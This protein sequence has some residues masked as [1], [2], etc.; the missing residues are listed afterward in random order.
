MTP[1]D[2]VVV[3]LETTGLDYKLDRILEIGA[4]RVR[5]GEMIDE[6]QA[7]VNPEVELREGNIAIHHITPA[8]VEAAPRIEVVLP[9]FLAFLG[10]DPVVAH[11]ALFDMNFLSFN[12]KTRLALEIENTAIDTL[13]LAREVFPGEKGLSLE[14][15]LELFGEPPRPLHRALEDAKALAAVFPPLIEALN[16]RRAYQRQQF[17]RIE[18]VA[19]RYRELGRLTELM[20]LEYK[21]LRRTLELYFRETGAD[22]VTVPGGETLRH[23]QNASY[24]FHPEEARSVL[25]ELGILERVQR[26]DREKLDRYL[27][28][29]RLSDEEKATVLDTRRFLGF[30]SAMSW[31]RPSVLE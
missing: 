17:E 12:A 7:L 20:Q 11:N 4:V 29:D 18:H 6:F 24:E 15:M 13:E 3:D 23:Q 30:R 2:Y 14:R 21:D 28:G 8:M 27:K 26:L 22:S 16:Q 9:E 1:R 25:S 5:A 19:L 31:E 10:K